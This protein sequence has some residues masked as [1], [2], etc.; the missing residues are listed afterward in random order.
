MIYRDIP[1]GPVVGSLPANAGD[2]RLIPAVGILHASGQLS[3]CATITEGRMP[4]SPCSA[5]GVAATVRN[6]C[7]TMNSS[8]HALQLEKPYGQ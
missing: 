7:T 1:G 3:P 5:T 2:M 6:L 4:W 8:L